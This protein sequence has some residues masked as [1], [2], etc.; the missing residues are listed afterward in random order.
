MVDGDYIAPP[1]NNSSI[2]VGIDLGLKSFAIT[3]D[4]KVFH[5]INKSKRVRKL[6]KQLK[7]AQRKL[8]RQYEQFKLYKKRGGAVT[9]HTKSN[10]KKQTL[11]VQKLH[12]RLANIREAYRQQVILDVVKTK[13]QYITLE[14]LNIKGMMKNR[15]LSKAIQQQGFYDFKSKLMAQCEKHHIEVREVSPWFPSSKM[16]H[17]CGVIKKDL[18]LKDRIYKCSCGYENDRDANAALNLRDAKEYTVLN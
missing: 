8:S 3:S 6:E 18:K 2:G 10:I 14:K 15:H 7:H 13:P 11:C 9:E 17:S 12:A 4:G 1:K 5:N 16:C